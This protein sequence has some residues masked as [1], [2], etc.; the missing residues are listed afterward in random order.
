MLKTRTLLALALGALV[1]GIAGNTV[2]A[3]E[4]SFKGKKVRIIVPFKEGGGSDIYART[5]QTYLAKYLPGSPSVIVENIP[6]GGSIKGANMFQNANPDGLT[7]MVASTSTFTSALFGGAAVRY[8]MTMWEP[9][10]LSPQGSVLF[11]TAKTGIAG[12]DAVT[13]SKTLAGQKHTLGIKSPTGSELR[14][15]AAFNLLGIDSIRPIFGLSAGERRQSMIRGEI[16]LGVEPYSGYSSK[17]TPYVK[18]GELAFFATLGFI[19]ADGKVVRDPGLPNAMTV[20]EI[21]K[22]LHGKDPSGPLWQAYLNFLNMG[23]MTSK[24]LSLPAGTPPEIVAAWKSAVDAT[25]QDPKFQE[26]SGK[27]LGPY[28][29][30]FGKEAKNA[31][32]GALNMNETQRQWLFNWV[33]ARMGVPVGK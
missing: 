25:L 5:L 3:N 30:V 26:I 23:V 20:P 4:V 13:A 10:V 2:L 33:E 18:S 9:V 24:S 7:A 15:V 12:Q 21:Y 19:N 28:P 14:A 27:V 32:R 16:N 8:D 29:Q 31:I 11:A 22:A 1:L 17:V 6:G